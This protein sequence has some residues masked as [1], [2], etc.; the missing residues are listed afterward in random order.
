MPRRVLMQEDAMTRRTLASLAASLALSLGLGACAV[1]EPAPAYPAYYP[2]P[3]AVYPAPYA[4]YPVY[5]A[6][7]AYGGSIFVFRGSFGGGHHHWR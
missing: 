2:P 5:P 1:Y 7:P 6:Y 4:Y 3:V